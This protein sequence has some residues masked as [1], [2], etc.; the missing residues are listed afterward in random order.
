MGV[1]NIVNSQHI[2]YREVV[3]ALPDSVSQYTWRWTALNIILI[4]AQEALCDLS[5]LQSLELFAQF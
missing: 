2:P 1:Y 3:Y 5:S 4:F